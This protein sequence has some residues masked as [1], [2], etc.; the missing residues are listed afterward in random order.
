MRVKERSACMMIVVAMILVGSIAIG[1]AQEKQD[2]RSNCPTLKMDCSSQVSVKNTLS[3]TAAVQGGDATVSPT[4]NWTVSAGTIESGQG[5][6][7]IQVSTAGIDPRSTVTAT[8]EVGGF[9]RS[10]GHGSN[11]ASCSAPVVKKAEAR[12]IDEYG[13][14][15]P[16]EEETRLDKFIIELN[17][18]PTALGYIVSYNARTGRPGDAQKAADRASIYLIRKRGLEVSRVVTV[19]GGS[20]EQPT[21]ELWLIPPGVRPPKPTAESLPASTTKTNN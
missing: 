15:T 19:T 9:D 8:V 18:D 1:S 7:T 21:V 4:Y 20:R 11:V 6:R 16:K 2:A 12:K 5:T 14:L 13:K 10:C 3:F 17:L